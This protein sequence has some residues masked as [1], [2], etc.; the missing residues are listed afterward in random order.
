MTCK[1]LNLWLLATDLLASP[2]REVRS[3]LDVCSPCHQR[4]HRLL[5]L[6]EKVHD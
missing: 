5:N 2:P 3:H 4:H 1:E 6:N